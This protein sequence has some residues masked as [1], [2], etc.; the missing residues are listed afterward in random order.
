MVKIK[1]FV[2]R[3][4]CGTVPIKIRKI[5]KRTSFFLY[6]SF[7]FKKLLHSTKGFVY[8]SFLIKTGRNS[9]FFVLGNRTKQI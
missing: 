4:L 1:G 7:V 5:F 6:V 2:Q 9:L 8:F 3:K